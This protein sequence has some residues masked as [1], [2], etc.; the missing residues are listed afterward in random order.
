MGGRYVAVPASLYLKRKDS[1][2]SHLSHKLV[3]YWA[4][5]GWIGRNNLLVNPKYGARIRLT[6]IL[7]DLPL[8]FDEPMEF[9][10]GDCYECVKACPAK[11]LGERPEDFNFERCFNL[12]STFIG[13]YQV[14]HH[15]CG[16]CIKVCKPWER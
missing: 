10:C 7:T 4:G 12:L 1:R 6:T 2:E 14:G 11:A 15:I 8:K 9:G 5:L 13:K 16:V 3:A